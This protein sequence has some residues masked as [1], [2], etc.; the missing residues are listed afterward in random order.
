MGDDLKMVIPKDRQDALMR[1]V[2][3][4]Q[5][6]GMLFIDGSAGEDGDKVYGFKGLYEADKKLSEVIETDNLEE[7]RAAKENYVAELGKMRELYALIRKELNP[8]EGMMLGNV[9]SFRTPW[10]PNELKNDVLC[11]AF[12]NGIFNLNINLA[13]NGISYEQFFENPGRATVRIIKNSAKHLEP[14]NILDH[15]DLANA[16]KKMAEGKAGN[17]SQSTASHPSFSTCI[18]KA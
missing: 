16:I 7:I 14:N 6:N 3:Y 15:D 18:I 8:N 10:L 5:E 13:Q 4:M 11:N 2:A 12:I 9:N 1:I 17:F